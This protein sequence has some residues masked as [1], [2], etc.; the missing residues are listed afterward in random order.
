MSKRDLTPASQGSNPCNPV[1]KNNEFPTELIIF[2]NWVCFHNKAVP[3]FMSGYGK[4][5][6]KL[7]TNEKWI[8]DFY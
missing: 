4:Y 1:V 2:Y 6:K 3:V 7:K 5:R 8:V